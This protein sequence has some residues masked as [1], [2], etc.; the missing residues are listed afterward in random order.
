MRLIGVIKK[1]AA[2]FIARVY[3]AVDPRNSLS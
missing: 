3:D 1:R 2:R